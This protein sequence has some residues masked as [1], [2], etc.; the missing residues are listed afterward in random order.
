MKSFVDQPGVPLVKGA[1]SCD[2]NRT[3]L[4]LSQSRYAPLGSKT[5]QGQSWQIP[6]CAKFGYGNATHK[7]C[8]LM[9]DRSATIISDKEGCADF[10][11]LNENGA[12]YYRFTMDSAAWDNVLL[13]LD[14]LNTREVLTVQD[15]LI[16]AYRAGEVDS[17]VVLKGMVA[18]AKHPEYEVAQGSGALLGFMEDE[19]DADEAL[20]KLT[21]DMYA[22]RYQAN[23]GKDTVEANLYLP[24]LASNL[25]ERGQDATLRAN[26]AKQGAA[27][28]GL[29][30]AADKTAIASN[31]LSTAL[32]ATMRERGADALEPLLEMVKN[33]SS[34]EK[35]AAIGA[36][37]KTTDPAIGDRLRSLALTDTETMTGRQALSLLSVMMGNETQSAQ[38]W[39]WLKANFEP[40]V[41]G[42]VP[43]VRKGGLPGLVR[44]YCSL[45]ERDEVKDFFDA[46]AELIPGY[47]RSLKQV[48]ESIELCAA[49]KQAKG[50]ELTAAL[51]AR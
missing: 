45:A 15:S 13:N 1:L 23:L 47:E 24:A 2:M 48:V 18:F 30:G 34:F 14:Q 28:L 42:R 27:Y 4:T 38:T 5:E 11:T 46:N 19:L 32:R 44:G 29:D 49:L 3:R 22:D 37:G 31:M 35:G 36:L 9:K 43:D 33:G 20:A 16:A 8:T 7:Q 10:V 12:G 41:T 25:I 51:E 50:D 6:V 26:F 39:E 40:F 17:D 21:R